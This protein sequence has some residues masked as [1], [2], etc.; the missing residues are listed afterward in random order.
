MA[1]RTDV[2]WRLDEA[3]EKHL[4]IE[5]MKFRIQTRREKVKNLV[6]KYFDPTKVATAKKHFELVEDIIVLMDAAEWGV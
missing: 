4:T 3:E 2:T 6:A 1:K 5:L